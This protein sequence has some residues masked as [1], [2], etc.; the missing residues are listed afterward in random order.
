M[1]YNGNILM[2]SPLEFKLIV[3]KLGIHLWFYYL[4]DDLVLF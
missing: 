2:V 1:D 4:S 3:L